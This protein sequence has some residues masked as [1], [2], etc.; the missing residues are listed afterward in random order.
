MTSSTPMP[1]RRERNKQAKLERIISAAS[2]L[3]AAHGADEV[4]T[5]QI[6]DAADIGTGTLFLYAKSKSE[7]LLMVQN[8]R[9]ER[10]LEQGIE[11]SKSAKT[12][13]EATMALLVPIIDCN[14]KHVDNGRFYLREMVFGD[15]AEPHHAEA[16]RIAALTEQAIAELLGTHRNLEAPE[17]A[18][19]ARAI[20]SIQFLAMATAADPALATAEVA[21]GI[22]AQI[23]AILPH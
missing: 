1:G 22:R 16:L 21:R 8:H 20:T 6:A 13:L 9:Y 5:Q 15:S 18:T 11:A 3:F 4:T 23:A 17:A 12:A 2:E 10:S 19:I 14:R 7:L